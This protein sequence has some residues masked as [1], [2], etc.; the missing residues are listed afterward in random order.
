MN[1]FKV[2]AS[3]PTERFRE[4]FTSAV[5]LWL[6]NP[7]MDHGIRNSFLKLFL[8]RINIDDETINKLPESITGE[9]NIIIKR[10]L[11]YPVSES[12]IDILLIINNYYICIENKIYAGSANNEKQLQNHYNGIKKVIQ[13]ELKIPKNIEP[14]IKIVF[15]VPS[16]KNIKVQKMINHLTTTT[17]LNNDFY[18]IEWKE[19]SY[20]IRKLIYKE[21]NCKIT[22]INEYTRHTLKA[23]SVFIDDKFKGY[24]PKK[25]KESL[26]DYADQDCLSY[27]EIVENNDIRFVGIQLGESTLRKMELDE[28]FKTRFW[29]S[30]K[31]YH[32]NHWISK[33]DFIS[34]VASKTDKEYTEN[35]TKN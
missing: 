28:I 18:T 26:F 2:L 13:K 23:F 27:E 32:R 21:Q 31:D 5:L 30:S 7:D 8:K 6:L 1:I 14:I 19:I 3:A 34:I 15:L 12:R 29:C 20:L 4:N 25:E 16:E 35:E 11:E 22:P 9:N 33:E 10:F 17:T 24:E